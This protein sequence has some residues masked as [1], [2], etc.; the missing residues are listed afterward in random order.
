MLNL[1]PHPEGGW[2]RQT[3]SDVP[4][5]S[6]AAGALSATGSSK[7]AG[8]TNSATKMP[9]AADVATKDATL[10]TAPLTQQ[11]VKLHSQALAGDLNRNGTQIF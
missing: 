5:A 7:S 3:F 6:K 2:Y 4:D 1:E 8:T 10:K 9:I 11:P